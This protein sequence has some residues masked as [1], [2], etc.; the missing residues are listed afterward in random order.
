MPGDQLEYSPSGELQTVCTNVTA[1]DDDLL[2]DIETYCLT[3]NSVDPNVIIDSD[4]AV[5]C[6]IIDNIN[7]KWQVVGSAIASLLFGDTQL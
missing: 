4:S 6:V 1:I 7:S 3:L 2:E 5:T